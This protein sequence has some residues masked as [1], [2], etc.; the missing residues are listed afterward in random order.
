MSGERTFKVKNYFDTA[1]ARLDSQVNPVDLSGSM[2]EQAGRYLEY[3]ELAAKAARQV[4]D[5]KLLLEN[6]EA[7]VHRRLKDDAVAAGEKPTVP[8][9]EKAVARHPKVI[10]MKKALNEARQIEAV[11]KV[12]VEAFRQRRDMLVQLGAHEREEMKGEL[13]IRARQDREEQYEATKNSI[14]ERRKIN[15]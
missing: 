10:A 8:D 1:Q 3:G 9:L 5:V 6:T 7:A 14:L 4:D 2:M 11:G 13:T 12:V 15:A